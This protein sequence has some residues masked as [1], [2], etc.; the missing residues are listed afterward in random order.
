VGAGIIVFAVL[1]AVITHP[2]PEIVKDYLPVCS[3]AARVASSSWLV[4]AF[5]YLI[6]ETLVVRDVYLFIHPE[7]IV[8]YGKVHHREFDALGSD[9]R[10]Q[11]W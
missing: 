7:A 4:V 8:P 9:G 3:L 1:L 6:L 5:N 11:P 10:G 2:W